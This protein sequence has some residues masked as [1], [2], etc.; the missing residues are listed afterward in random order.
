MKIKPIVEIEYCPKCGWLLRSAY[1]AQELLTTFADELG[2]V[3]LVPSPV[4]GRFQIRLDKKELFDRKRNGGFE[5][6]KLYKI[7]IRD[8]ICKD[9][10]LGHTERSRSK[11]A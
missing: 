2:G 1:V 9:K 3:T 4:T 10:P 6:I 7:M 11:E 5:D 8:L